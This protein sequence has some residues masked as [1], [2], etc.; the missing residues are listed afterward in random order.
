LNESDAICPILLAA[1]PAKDAPPSSQ[2]LRN[3][4]EY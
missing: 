1:V 3:S 4:R 2:L